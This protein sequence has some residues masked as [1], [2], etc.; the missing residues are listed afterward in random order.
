MTGATFAPPPRPVSLRLHPRPRPI[1]RRHRLPT[2]SRGLAALCV[3]LAIVSSASAGK[4]VLRDPGIPDGEISRYNVFLRDGAQEVSTHRVAT[5][6]HD[7]GPAYEIATDTKTMVLLRRDLTPVSITR[8]NEDASIDWR[9]LYRDDR[10]NYVFPGPRRNRVEKVDRNRYDV[11][12]IT[13][14]VRGFPFGEEDEVK[15]QLVTM[16][17]IV[18]VGFKIVGEEIAR[19]PAGD[20]PCYKLRAGLTGIKGRLY[21]R[22]IYFWV[23]KAPPHRMVRQEDEGVTDVARTELIEWRVDDEGGAP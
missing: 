2:G 15:F 19:V 12:A 9:L 18:G 10:V 5:N 14:V 7:R 11:N 21:T 8:R 23:E 4:P 1:L 20:F 6:Q 22:K 13:H 17:R 3:C 16:D